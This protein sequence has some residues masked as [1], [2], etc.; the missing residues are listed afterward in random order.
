M[1]FF[2]C[3]IFSLYFIRNILQKIEIKQKFFFRLKTINF[4]KLISDKQNV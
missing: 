4:R 1:F 2:N 3:N